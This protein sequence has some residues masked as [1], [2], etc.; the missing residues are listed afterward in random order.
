MDR[1]LSSAQWRLG[2][3]GTLLGA[4]AHAQD[5]ARPTVEP[6]EEVVV[7]GQRLAQQRSI[8]RKRKSERFVDAVSAD[9]IGRL[10]DRNVAEALA[11]L[12][13]VSL[14]TDQG[15]G[16]FVAIRGVNSSLNH[17]T[18]NGVAAGTP[19]AEGGG[20]RVPFDV[21]GGE[22]LAAVEVVKVQTPDMDAQGIGGTINVIT[23]GPFDHEQQPL[24]L[25]SLQSGHDELNGK[26][27]YAGELRV[28][29]VDASGAWGWLFGATH[30]Y[31]RSEARGIY[32]DDWGVAETAEG[33]SSIVPEN[34]KH[35]LYDRERRRTGVNATL[36]WR[37]TAGNRYFLRGFLS[38]LEEDEVRQRFAYFFR[39]NP[40]SLTQTTGTSTENHRE[41]NLR[42]EHK[43]KH[44]LNFAIG[45]EN[46]LA[47]AWRF[48]YLAQLND[49][50]QDIPNRNWEWR[51]HDSG[52][53]HWRV[54]GN[55]LVNVTTGTAN[56]LDPAG[57]AFVRLR[58]R[59]H[60]TGERGYNAGFNLE[61]SLWDEHSYLRFGARYTRTSRANEASQTTYVPGATD[62]TLAEFGHYRGVSLNHI[63][64]MPR[65]TVLV[66]VAAANSFLDANMRSDDYFDVDEQ[67]TFAAQVQSDY[68]VAEQVLAGYVMAH[69]DLGRWSLVAGVRTER[70]EMR[71]AGFALDFEN[72]SARRVTDKSS[73]TSVL[74]S[75]VAQLDLTNEL[76]LRAAWTHT[77]GRPNYEHLAPTSLLERD[78]TAGSLR[79]GNPDLEARES[80]NFDVALEWYFAPG[81]L[82]AAGV[83]RK[84]IENEIVSRFRT[85][86]DFVFRGETFERFTITTTE[87]AHSSRVNGLEVSYQQRFDFLPAPF[88]GFGVAL[89]YAAL[90]S[91]TRVAGR[92]DT[93]PF[94]RQP[95]WTRSG[96]LFYQKAGFELAIALSKADGFLAEI[97]DAS[98]TDLYADEYGRLDLR[99]SYSFDGRYGLFFEWHNINNEPAIEYQGAIGRQKTHY[100]VYGQTW[101]VGFT[102]RL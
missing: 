84:H 49:N 100:E 22:L 62:W 48:D 28:A 12:A 55:G 74:P 102:A 70:T 83:F 27:P 1:R 66:D 36:E 99:A 5:I 7:S 45:G 29:R 19:E 18:I 15:E 58:T 16:R 33:A 71:S 3:L 61:R 82:L 32:Q 78:G 80:A 31:R 87:N 60:Q 17:F 42:F 4:L 6:L 52:S 96:S 79:I 69:W 46:E 30:S 65:S 24:M 97:S 37:P 34:V 23:A 13:G 8:D 72:A 54:D 81:G 51:G 53:G 9:E 95:D 91:A 21:I 86:D 14:T 47:S 40:Q 73:Y 50:E 93:L 92:D 11:R 101:Y 25:M 2:V 75:V 85:L 43:E 98:H 68:E 67:E 88:D 39:N 44:F 77:L 10:P 57:L 41:Q 56:P 76:V 26:H 90:D 94:V 89:T 20:R 35:G 38:K 59:E 63:D 64:G